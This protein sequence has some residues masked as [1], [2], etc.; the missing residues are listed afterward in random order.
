[1]VTELMKNCYECGWL[2]VKIDNK[3]PRVIGEDI[4]ALANGAVLNDRPKA[5]M[6]WGVDDGLNTVGTAF[7]PHK[8]KVGNEDL[9]SWLRRNLS[10]N[11]S[12]EFE[13]GIAR[14]VNVVV[15]TVGRSEAFPVSFAGKEYVREGSCTKRL[16]N[17][18]MLAERLWTKLNSKYYES[19]IAKD[20]LTASEVLEL[21]DFVSFFELARTPIPNEQRDIMKRLTDEG[22]VVEQSN[23][24]YSVTHLGALA[25]A[26][27]LS[28]FG[29]MERKAV[30]VVRYGEGEGAGKVLKDKV[31][32]KGYA[33]GFGEMMMFVEALLPSEYEMSETQRKTATAYPIPSVKEAIV[34]SLVHQDLPVTYIRNII[35]ISDS[36]IEVSNPGESLIDVK[37]IIDA[38][39]ATRNEIFSSLM[40][41]LGLAEGSGV[42][43]DRIVEGCEELHSPPPDV[44]S[45]LGYTRVTLRQKVEFGS[46]TREEKVRACY[47]HACARYLNGGSMNN[48]S[49]RER[50]G[51][52]ETMAS[53]VSR[54][55]REAADA[56]MIKTLDPSAAPKHL[57]YVPFWA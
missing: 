54:I 18:P 7:D 24:L 53:P 45:E 27:R 29:R 52:K 19:G 40:R 31:F 49:L 57:R 16:L 34:N 1:M 44:R 30:R 20:D 3:D 32:D 28:A 23:A 41:R 48:T 37:R 11:A 17:I 21:L 9:V 55:I 6:V 56:G 47:Q 46:M 5:Y 43:W 2:E 12:F 8:E 10:G 39:P 15:L 33:A 51:L 36:R 13:S 22:L 14:G 50:F 38:K 25:F 35:E 26:R 42:G 4:S